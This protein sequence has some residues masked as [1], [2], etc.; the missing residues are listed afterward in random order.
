MARADA[1]LATVQQIY[2]KTLEPDGLST[3][4]RSIAAVSRSNHRPCLCG[5]RRGRR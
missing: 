5:V 4:L 3:V 1:I 2:D